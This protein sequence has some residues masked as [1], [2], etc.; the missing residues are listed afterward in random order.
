MTCVHRLINKAFR[1]RATIFSFVDT[2]TRQSCVDRCSLQ[3]IQIH[4]ISLA[5]VRKG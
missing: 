1:D 4:I 2:L 5:V 3:D